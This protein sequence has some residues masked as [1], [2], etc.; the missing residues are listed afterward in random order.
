MF[1]KCIQNYLLKWCEE[2]AL[3]ISASS[4]DFSSQYEM[5]LLDSNW[6]K[7][8]LILI[9]F[10]SNNKYDKCTCKFVVINP[11]LL[12]CNLEKIAFNCML[13]A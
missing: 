10:T 9:D 7:A 3:R 6:E 12:E 11:D 1:T 4:S 8:H 5:S 13:F 2:H